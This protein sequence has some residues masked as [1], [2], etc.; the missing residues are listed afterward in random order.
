MDRRATLIG[1]FLL[2]SVLGLIVLIPLWYMAAPLFAR[3]PTWLAGKAMEANTLTA[4]S[5]GAQKRAGLTACTP[6]EL[7]RIRQLNADYGARFGFPFVLCVRGPRGTGLTKQQILDNFA[8]RLHPQGVVART[9]NADVND[10]FGI[11]ARQLIGAAHGRA[12][13][14]GGRGD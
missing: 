12:G 1:R 2:L 6:E 11:K 10:V 7:A 5:T 8:R 9:A 14:C 3:P 13:R 4:E